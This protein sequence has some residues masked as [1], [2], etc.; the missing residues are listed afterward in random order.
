MATWNNGKDNTTGGTTVNFNNKQYVTRKDNGQTVY[1]VV[2]STNTTPSAASSAELASLKADL[3]QAVQNISGSSGGA[4]FGT[5]EY[6]GSNSTT[7][8]Y[9]RIPGSETIT[10]STDVVSTKLVMKDGSI[11][12]AAILFINCVN[13]NDSTFKQPDKARAQ[14]M[15]NVPGTDTYPSCYINSRDGSGASASGVNFVTGTYTGDDTGRSGPTPDGPPLPGKIIN[16]GGKPITLRIYG[17]KAQILE[18]ENWRQSDYGVY[19]NQVDRTRE[20]QDVVIT[21]TGFEAHKEHT[22]KTKN[23]QSTGYI[24]FRGP[25]QIGHTYTYEALIPAA[26]DTELSTATGST[27]GPGTQ[28]IVP[29]H[30]DGT[31][32]LRAHI[33]QLK[34][35][36]QGDD[37]FMEMWVVGVM[38][39]GS[40]A[41]VS[42]YNT[43]QDRVAALE[44][45][46]AND[47]GPVRIGAVGYT[48][49]V[50]YKSPGYKLHA[51]LNVG[52]PKPVISSLPA[53]NITTSEPG[54]GD[55]Y[56]NSLGQKY[57]LV[58]SHWTGFGSTGQISGIAVRIE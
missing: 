5:V 15:Y 14:M 48:Y 27:Y 31:V 53:L 34:E 49:E 33:N 29:V 30:P 13:L 46:T 45:S 4:G 22:D 40:T 42:D 19:D 37:C 1:D 24:T 55:V 17:D 2:T 10:T 25:N 20:Y 32:K 9:Q 21:D 16:I 23:N 43:L 41:P 18:F 12:S 50:S 52:T 35:Q 39:G 58:F 3:E 44:A 57:M 26:T 38:G 36:Y 28:A 11:P 8:F 56:A 54:P 51:R 47:S 7:Y 6:A